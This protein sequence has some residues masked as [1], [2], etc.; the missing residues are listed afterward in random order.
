VTL[1]AWIWR[2][3][4]RP[5]WQVSRKARLAGVAPRFYIRI[6][7]ESKLYRRGE[8]VLWAE[9]FPKME[10]NERA[11]A[12]ASALDSCI[13][14]FLCLDCPRHARGVVGNAEAPARV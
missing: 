11:T 12:A 4:G 7:A 5:A 1:R 13:F 10:L 8:Q 3:A 2:I 9:P 6:W 14:F